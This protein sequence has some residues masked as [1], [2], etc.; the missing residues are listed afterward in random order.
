[1]GLRGLLLPTSSV[2]RMAC[3]LLSVDAGGV[4]DTGLATALLSAGGPA[5]VVSSFAGVK[6]AVP[7]PAEGSSE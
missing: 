2:D 7:S 3:D 5:A 1:M 4:L 6:I